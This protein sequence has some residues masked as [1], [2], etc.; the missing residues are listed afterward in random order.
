MTTLA[1]TGSASR[2]VTRLMYL[3]LAI[4]SGVYAGV[5]LSKA[6]S[7]FPALEPWFAWSSWIFSTAAPL[8]LGA[9]ALWAPLRTLRIVA[10]IY[11]LLFLV[12]ML[13][14]A[15]LQVTPGLPGQ[16]SPWTNDIMTVPTIAIAISWRARPV[17]AYVIVS[18][19]CSGIVRYASDP[20]IGWKLAALD[21]SYNL[22]TNAVFT[23]LTLVT[24][25]GA[26]RLDSAAAA[27]QLETSRQAEAAA[28]VQQRVRIDALVHDHVLSALL[29][30]SRDDAP[31]APSETSRRRRS[32][33]CRPRARC[34][35]SRSPRRTSSAVCGHRSPLRATASA[36]RPIWAA[37]C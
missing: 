36:S 16:S 14:W 9:L 35:P 33:L 27:A 15:P 2:R 37:A 19:L 5:G 28:R 6:F 8:I 25:S 22:L 3:S 20:A 11:G 7:E 17:W 31:R 24:R 30:A 12:V 32:R 13:V 23:S 26:S 29:I 4:G 18:A 34:D 1:A 10:S 21:T